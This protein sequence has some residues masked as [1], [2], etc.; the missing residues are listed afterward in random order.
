M[1]LMGKIYYTI[2]THHQFQ[3]YAAA[4]SGIRYEETNALTH[5]EDAYLFATEV[6]LL[7]LVYKPGIFSFYLE[8]GK[9]DLAVLK[10]GVGIKL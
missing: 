1:A 2:Y 10:A 9:S 6:I 4:A 3:A 7:G 8:F 5:N